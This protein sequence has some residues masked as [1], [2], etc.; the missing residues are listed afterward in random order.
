[1]IIFRT[2]ELQNSSSLELTTDIANYC[3]SLIATFLI[4][5]MARHILR[6]VSIIL[7]IIG[8]VKSI[9]EY[10]GIIG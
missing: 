1:M 10:C 8:I 5:G 9:G 4:P 6:H 2:L 7:G 3:M